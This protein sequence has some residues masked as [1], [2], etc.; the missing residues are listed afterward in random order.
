MVIPILDVL[1]VDAKGFV[2]LIFVSILA[3]C[4]SITQNEIPSLVW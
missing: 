4:M 2:G 3:H 1:A